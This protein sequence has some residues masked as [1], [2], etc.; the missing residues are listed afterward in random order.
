MTLKR[1]MRRG[2][3]GFCLGMLLS[4]GLGSWQA[5]YSQDNPPAEEFALLPTELS[6]DP[7]TDSPGYVPDGI[8]ISPTPVGSG[9]RAVIGKDDRVL[10]TSG[11]YP[12]S[13]IG[14][15]EQYD[16]RGNLRGWCTGTLIERNLILTNAHCVIDGRTNQLTRNEIVFR[17]NMI[18]GEA[19]DSAKAVAV[20]YGT[21]FDDGRVADDWA[22]VEIDEPLGDYYGSLGWIAPALQRPEVIELLRNKLHLV[23]YSF[24]FPENTLGHDPGETPGVHHHCTIIGLFDEDRF[25]HNCDTNS[26]ASGGTLIGKL[27]SG[28]YVILGLHA[29]AA[30]VSDGSVFNF[31]MKVDRWQDTAREMIQ[32]ARRHRES[33]SSLVVR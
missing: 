20:Q 6:L 31:G 22:L 16:A 9:Q 28:K 12:W 29:G 1:W 24:D 19:S 8:D 33:V 17:A 7:E 21:N 18:G 15:L 32:N 10:M 3:I 11:A 5:L 30:E 13:T 4:L 26:G 27:T 2:I 23:G 25:R 14:R